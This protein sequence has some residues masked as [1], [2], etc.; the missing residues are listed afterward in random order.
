MAKSQ[1]CFA[2]RARNV[3]TMCLKVAAEAERNQ[4]R[5]KADRWRLKAAECFRIAAGHKIEG[6]PL[7]TNVI[8]LFG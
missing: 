1:Y 2:Q 5:Q 8:R 6:Q 7:G 3:A 4:D